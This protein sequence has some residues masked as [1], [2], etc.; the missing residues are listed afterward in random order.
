M[1]FNCIKLNPL[2]QT[3]CWSRLNRQTLKLWAHLPP[4]S[5]GKKA[6]TS[7]DADFAALRGAPW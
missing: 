7:I 6:H 3:G 4:T 1:C 5:I 2:K